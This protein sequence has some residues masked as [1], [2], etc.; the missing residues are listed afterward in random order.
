MTYFVV[1]LEAS[2]GVE[3]QVSEGDDSAAH[4]FLETHEKILS[5]GSYG[6]EEVYR[7]VGLRYCH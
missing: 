2:V 1:V 5:A 7:A 4:S 6:G 3:V